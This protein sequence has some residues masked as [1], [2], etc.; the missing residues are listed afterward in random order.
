MIIKWRTLIIFLFFFSK[1][2][3]LDCS[4]FQDGFSGRSCLLFPVSLAYL[5][6]SKWTGNICFLADLLSGRQTGKHH[7]H[8]N[9][10]AADTEDVISLWTSTLPNKDSS[11]QG[12]F[13]KTTIRLTTMTIVFSSFD[14]IIILSQCGSG[15]RGLSNIRRAGKL[16][17]IP[18]WRITTTVVPDL[19]IFTTLVTSLIFI[20]FITS[21]M[22]FTTFITSGQ[23]FLNTA[24]FGK[25]CF[26][27]SSLHQQLTI[28][29]QWYCIMYNF[30]PWNILLSPSSL[31]SKSSTRVRLSAPVSSVGWLSAS[32]ISG[33]A[34]YID[35]T[36][37]LHNV[38]SHKYSIQ[39]SGGNPC[40]E[41]NLF[42]KFT[43]L[44]QT[45]TFHI[46][47]LVFSIKV[48]TPL[49]A[50]S[51]EL[52]GASQRGSKREV[53]PLTLSVWTSSSSS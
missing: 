44:S 41:N 9:D 22:N 11:C 49:D 23:I 37:R 25:K 2:N 8:C 53:P 21:L 24:Y 35:P 18:L 3:Q 40:K 6:D 29:L 13:I 10:N 31:I 19:F 28:S 16:K 38:M 51:K 50:Q 15:L 52:G 1:Y 5:W 46:F 27:Q 42:G 30:P 45:L 17:S 48:P 4:K 39:N 20:T 43:F 33:G 14:V 26:F 32:Q 34:T 12:N 47:V 36:L 7:C